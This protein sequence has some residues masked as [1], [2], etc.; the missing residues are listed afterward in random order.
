LRNNF[1]NDI[2]IVNLNREK[3]ISKYKIKYLYW[4]YKLIKY[5]KIMFRAEYQINILIRKR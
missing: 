2:K 5:I 4:L 3:F 1:N